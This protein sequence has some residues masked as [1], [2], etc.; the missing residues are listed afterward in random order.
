M[1]LETALV[2]EGIHLQ[3]GNSSSVCF[4]NKYMDSAQLSQSA[5]LETHSD[6]ACAFEYLYISLF[7]W[8]S[9]Q[10]LLLF[11][12]LFHV[13]ASNPGKKTVNFSCFPQTRSCFC[14]DRAGVFLALCTTRCECVYNHKAGM[15][16]GRFLL[17][18]M[19]EIFPR[20]HGKKNPLFLF[21]SSLFLPSLF[22]R[23]LLSGP[24]LIGFIFNTSL[25]FVGSTW[26]TVLIAFGRHPLSS[27]SFG[28]ISPPLF[29]SLCLFSF[30][31]V[32]SSSCLLS[33][34]FF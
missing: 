21:L 14:F 25:M 1:S 22:T 30:L 15:T 27:P 18:D 6:I 2:G 8:I 9:N 20:C 32:L 29:R 33:S 11:F 34:F 13:A 17:R 23:F 19:W 10:P 28:L 24:C 5:A 31:L 3:G 7:V 26:R 12:S 4:K 16:M